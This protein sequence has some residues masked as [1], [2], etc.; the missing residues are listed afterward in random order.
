MNVQTHMKIF[1]YNF[2]T[3]AL[4]V[5]CQGYNY[6]FVPLYQYQC[7]QWQFERQ[8]HHQDVCS[9]HIKGKYLNITPNFKNHHMKAVSHF[10][11]KRHC[12]NINQNHQYF[13]SWLSLMQQQLQQICSAQQIKKLKRKTF[14]HQQESYNLSLS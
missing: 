5:Q 3:K 13:Y 6:Q 7:C 9:H 10:C 4:P 8:Y 2:R 11:S 1:I 14:T 12:Q